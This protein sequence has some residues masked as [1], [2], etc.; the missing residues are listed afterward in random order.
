MNATDSN[1]WYFY[2]GKQ[3]WEG[4]L[5]ILVPYSIRSVECPD[6][7]NVA[8]PNGEG[9]HD[10]SEVYAETPQYTPDEYKQKFCRFDGKFWIYQKQTKE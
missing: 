9:G 6:G 5:G 10:A 3:Y 8:V 2:R 4:P 7:A 1:E